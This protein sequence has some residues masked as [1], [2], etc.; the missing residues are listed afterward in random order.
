MLFLE[1]QEGK[2]LQRQ[3]PNHVEAETYIADLIVGFYDRT[4]VIVLGSEPRVI[5]FLSLKV[6]TVLI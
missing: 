6:F 5:F 2:G 3:Y 1:R 4:L